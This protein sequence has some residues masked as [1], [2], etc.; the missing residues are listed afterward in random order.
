MQETI[1]KELIGIRRNIHQNPE[2]GFRERKTASLVCDTLKAL[3]I[4]ATS[5]IALTGVTA[6]IN[7][8]PGRCIALR[9]DMDALPIKEESGIEFTSL[10]DGI[11]HACGHDI[12]TTMLLGAAYLLSKVSFK[13]KV[14]FIFQPS[15]EG[16]YPEMFAN[17]S[18]KSGG[19]RIIEAGIVDD[20]DAALGL[21]VHPLLPTGQIGFCTGHALAAVGFFKIQVF[22]KAGHAAFPH[23]TIDAIA[24]VGQIISSTQFIVSRYTDPLEPKVISFTKINGGI[25]ENIIAGEVEILGTV[26]ALD[27]DTYTTVVKCLKDVLIGIEKITGTVITIAFNLNYPSL[28]NDKTIHENLRSPLEKVFGIEN[29]I[30]MQPA[31]GGEDFAFFAQKVPSMFYFLGAGDGINTYFLHHAKVIFDEKCISYG[32]E[33]LAEAALTLLA[34]DSDG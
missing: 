17:K 19:Q 18:F 12:H 24:A 28:L 20:V 14:K 25:N 34:F 26:R 32:A 5:G 4:S 22:G 11:M 30:E 6:E 10:N 3:G 21:H 29:I 27:M 1:L 15:E 7:N 8:G 2:L 33:F 9:A 23:K 13:G 16:T 31:M